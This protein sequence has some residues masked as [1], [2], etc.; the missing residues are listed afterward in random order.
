[1]LVLIKSL[2]CVQAPRRHL[3]VSAAGTQGRCS[4]NWTPLEH[5]SKATWFGF[6][7]LWR[8]AAVTSAGAGMHLSI[9]GG[10]TSVSPPR[11]WVSGVSS[12]RPVWPQCLSLRW[13][14]RQGLGVAREQKLKWHTQGRRWLFNYCFG[15]VTSPKTSIDGINKDFYCKLSWEMCWCAAFFISEPKLV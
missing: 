2:G 12:C 4:P 3:Y 11:P 1:M 10:L 14:R 6:D 13:W 9:P 7:S 8:L 15:Q 5:S